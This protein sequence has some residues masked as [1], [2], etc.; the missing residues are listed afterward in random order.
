VPADVFF[1]WQLVPGRRR[2][3]PWALAL[4][5]GEPFALGAIWEPSVGTVDP[6]PRVAILTTGPNGVVLPLHERM[7][8]I[9]A[10]DRYV[11]WLDPR[12]PE[13][14]Y[15]EMVMPWPS[16]QLVAWPITELVNS[17]AHDDARVLA[18]ANDSAGDLELF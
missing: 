15:R 2:K 16:D 17:V 8:V 18:R 4:P 10:P 1:E 7:P 3:Q 14:A 5:D 12:T 13:P 6:E 9:I 11:D